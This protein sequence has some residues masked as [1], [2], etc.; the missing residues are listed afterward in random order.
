[1]EVLSTEN[2]YFF[3]CPHCKCYLT[4]EKEQLNCR[5]FR[6]GYYYLDTPIGIQLTNQVNPHAS[7]EECERLIA[8]NKIIGCGKPFRVVNRDLKLFAEEC[9][10][11]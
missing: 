3:Q 11:I 4:V 1:M 9:D 7:K 5:I 10:Y 6:H 8:E 2:V